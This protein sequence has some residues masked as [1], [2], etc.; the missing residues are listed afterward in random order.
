MKKIIQMADSFHKS[1]RE[2]SKNIRIAMS[3]KPLKKDFYQTQ[4]NE[5]FKPKGLWY[6]FGGLL[7]R[8]HSG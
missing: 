8:C 6:A 3:D 5:G 1:A 2:F 7:Q 4:D